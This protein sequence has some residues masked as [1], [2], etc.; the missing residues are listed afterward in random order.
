M[1]PQDWISDTTSERLGLQPCIRAVPF[2]YQ[3][4]FLPCLMGLAATAAVRLAR[5]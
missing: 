5:S 4:D 3:P 1:L 2:F